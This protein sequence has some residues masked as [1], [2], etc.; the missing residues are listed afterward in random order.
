MEYN[1]PNTQIE[2]ESYRKIESEKERDRDR[3]RENELRNPMK[4]L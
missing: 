1:E 3:D 4:L 2:Q